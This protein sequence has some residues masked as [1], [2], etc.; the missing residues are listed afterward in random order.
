MKCQ[1]Q[2]TWGCNKF[3]HCSRPHV[4]NATP[5]PCQYNITA[6][7]GLSKSTATLNFST[8]FHYFPPLFL[9][10]CLWMMLS[11]LFIPMRTDMLANHSSVLSGSS[12]E[13]VLAHNSKMDDKVKQD[14]SQNN[15]FWLSS[16]KLWLYPSG[17]WKIPRGPLATRLLTP[18]FIAQLSLCDRFFWE[19]IS[20]RHANVIINFSS[21]VWIRITNIYMHWLLMTHYLNF[22]KVHKSSLFVRLTKAKE[23][24]MPESFLFISEEFCSFQGLNQQRSVMERDWFIF[25]SSHTKVSF[26][27]L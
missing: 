22:F 1:W 20:N 21:S 15:T 23:Q 3:C 14:N 9:G 2:W 25:L 27:Y 5:C 4:A 6:Y 8:I 10:T 11:S 12:L 24:I 26:K 7:K 18:Y 17:T 19:I 13:M 16:S